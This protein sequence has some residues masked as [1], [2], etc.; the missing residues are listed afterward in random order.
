ML[1]CTTAPP[2]P[3]SPCS[4]HPS[5]K[6]C[7]CCLPS[8]FA[9]FSIS[10]CNRTSRKQASKKESKRHVYDGVSFEYRF[11]ASAMS[12]SPHNTSSRAICNL[13]LLVTV[14][15]GVYARANVILGKLR[16]CGFL[17][18]DVC[19]ICKDL[20]HVFVIVECAHVSIHELACYRSERDADVVLRPL[21]GS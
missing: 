7:L 13:H 1:C 3:C 12:I 18:R 20:Y 5:K 14:V 21:Y 16:K 11:N 19:W 2:H 10:L 15:L 17:H 9:R 8:F 4:R 6:Q